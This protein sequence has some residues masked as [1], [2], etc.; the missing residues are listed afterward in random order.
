MDNP[1][2]MRNGE[3]VRDL[4]RVLDRFANRKTGNRL[5]QRLAFEQF[6]HDVRRALMSADV[7]DRENVRMVERRRGAR[8]L[9]EARQALDIGR[10]VVRQHFDG[11]VAPEPRIAGAIDLAHPTGADR[12][13]DLIRA[14]AST[15][16]QRHLTLWRKLDPPFGPNAPPD[17]GTQAGKCP[18]TNLAVEDA[19]H[20][21]ATANPAIVFTRESRALMATSAACTRSAQQQ[22]SVPWDA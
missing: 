5:A 15:W 13:H 8:F 1:L 6:G 7:V 16:R 18:A 20:G 3:P 22:T 11:H 21:P 12:T 9:L 19:Q 10:I 2:F 4:D 17:I 14:E